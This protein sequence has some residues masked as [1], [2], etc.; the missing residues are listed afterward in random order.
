[1]NSGTRPVIGIWMDWTAKSSFSPRPHYAIREGYFQA[2]WDAGGM[3]I[4]IPLLETGSHAYLNHVAGVVVPGGDYPSPS[5][6]YGDDHGIRD[7]HPRTV[8]NEQLIRDMLAMDKPF[9]A[10]CAG[11]QE[12][13]AATG[14]LLYWRVKES[15]PG[16]KNHRIDALEETSHDIDVLPGSLLHKL[17][18]TERFAVNSHHHEAVRSLGDGLIVSGRS[19]DGVI[20]AIEVP[21]KKFALGVQWHPEFGLSEAD[22]AL[23][24][25]LVNAAR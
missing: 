6:W 12:L 19:P 22:H 11:H 24:V 7:E 5:R 13:A 15:L 17:V 4:G 8:V 16:A 23:F 2:V 1:M 9:L 14:G 21:G 25:G 20:E 10:I 3:P 18:G